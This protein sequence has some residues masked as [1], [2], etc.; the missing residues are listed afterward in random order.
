MP[1]LD[2][3]TL[4]PDS[5]CPFCAAPVSGNLTSWR[6]AE[7]HG[8]DATDDGLKIVLVDSARHARKVSDTEVEISYPCGH[9]SSFFRADDLPMTPADVGELLLTSCACC[10]SP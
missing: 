9:V 4:Q 10:E 5:I 6:C 2:Q 7:G 3:L 8:S 1:D